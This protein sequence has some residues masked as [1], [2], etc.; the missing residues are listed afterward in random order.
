[1]VKY[2]EYR[3][4]DQTVTYQT[5]YPFGLWENFVAAI[6]NGIP[7]EFY[8]DI[9]A[10]GNGDHF[11]VATGYSEV[12]GVRSYVAYNTWDTDL[13]WYDFTYGGDGLGY[14]VFTGMFFQPIPEPTIIAPAIMLLILLRRRRRDQ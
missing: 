2:A 3:G 5:L 4:Y 10:D 12:G 7:V 9:D 6:D 14:G 11:V 13:H 1:M 8:V